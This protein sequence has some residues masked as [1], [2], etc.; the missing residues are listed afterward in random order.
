MCIVLP[1]CLGVLL[2]RGYTLAV[3]FLASLCKEDTIWSALSVPF[4]FVSSQLAYLVPLMQPTTAYALKK[5]GPPVALDFRLAYTSSRS[6]LSSSCTSFRMQ[7]TPRV[8]RA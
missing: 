3:T 7:R 6:G 1:F 4:P 8:T 5:V 2:I